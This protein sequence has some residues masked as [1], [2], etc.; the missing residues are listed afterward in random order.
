VLRIKL[1]PDGRCPFVS[2]QGCLVYAH[3][4]ACCRVYPLAR[5][6]TLE[7]DGQVREL[8]LA[9]DTPDCLGWQQERELSVAD[10]LA[11]QE[12]APYSQANNRIARLFMHPRR[13]PV[14]RLDE[15]QT[16]AVVLALY[17][18]DV[19]RQALATP[20]LARPLGLDGPAPSSDEQLL[21]LGQDWLC[22][23]LFGA[24]DNADSTS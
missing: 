24:V 9:Q 8:L 5:A 12:L 20:A 13:P 16:H 2:P 21:D 17:N 3:R 4:P 11:E 10:Y 23:R 15:K 19:L 22:E 6:V 7:H 18:L 14:L 1:A